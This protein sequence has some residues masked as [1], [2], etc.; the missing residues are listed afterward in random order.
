M[1][2]IICSIWRI[3]RLIRTIH[4]E[5]QVKSFKSSFHL[6]EIESFKVFLNRIAPIDVTR[7]SL[8]HTHSQ[9]SV[10]VFPP[11]LHSFYRA[12]DCNQRRFTSIASASHTTFKL[13]LSLCCVEIDAQR[14]S[15]CR[16]ASVRKVSLAH[17]EL[18]CV[19]HANANG[20]VSCV[21]S[22]HVM[23]RG[24]VVCGGKAMDNEEVQKVL[25]SAPH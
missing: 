17:I 5:S 13:L 16:T 4:R 8:A 20:G 9:P 24:L 6:V 18:T 19:T 7:H 14:L 23:M 21:S 10:R 25:H 3:L 22:S 1:R 12:P 15:H 2:T 11:T